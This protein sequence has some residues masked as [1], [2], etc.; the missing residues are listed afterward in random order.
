MRELTVSEIAGPYNISL[1]ATT[2]HL[3][4][5]E[6]AGLVRSH[7]LGRVRSCE[8]IPNAMDDAEAWIRKYRRF[9]SMQLDALERHLAP[10]PNKE[11]L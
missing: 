8:L 2:K 10:E 11:I 3:Q 1:P 4:V 9:W 7:K 5:L 6:Q